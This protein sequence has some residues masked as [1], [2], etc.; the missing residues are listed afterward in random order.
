MKTSYYLHLRI[1]CSTILEIDFLIRLL[2]LL[3]EG[4]K[5]MEES[6]KEGMLIPLVNRDWQMPKMKEACIQITNSKIKI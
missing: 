6:S 4:L 1:L 3:K 2:L 5:I